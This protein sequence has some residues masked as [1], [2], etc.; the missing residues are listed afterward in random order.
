MN[1]I[2][3]VLVTLIMCFFI[4]CVAPTVVE[5]HQFV[6]AHPRNFKIELSTRN[7]FTKPF[8]RENLIG[9]WKSSQYYAYSV[10]YDDKM[11]HN[12]M[13]FELEYDFKPDGTYTVFCTSTI[14]EPHKPVRDS[15]G[16]GKWVYAVR[17]DT[18][19]G[20]LTLQDFP[21]ERMQKTAIRA[22][23]NG[24]QPFFAVH[25]FDKD[26]LILTALS[27]E[28]GSQSLKVKAQK[29]LYPLAYFDWK[30]DRY[31]NVK[32]AVYNIKGHSKWMV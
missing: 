1:K 9:K 25:W 17:E 10:G 30:R 2:I 4:G 20:Q 23:L 16:E 29:A 28:I 5:L 18:G 11:R 31:Y 27:E 24:R 22:M 6:K 15:L 32:A 21:P 12:K 14:Y 13:Y 7:D 3:G 8:P 26:K 19:I